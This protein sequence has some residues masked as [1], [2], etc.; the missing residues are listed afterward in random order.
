MEIASVS[1]RIEE[2]TD[3]AEA[4]RRAS[5]RAAQMGFDDVTI[6][7]AAIVV[8]EAATN[9]IKH[10]GGGEVLVGPAIN[11][12]VSGLQVIAVDKGHG[13]PNVSASLRDGY[14]T[15]GTAGNG[16]GAIARAA[17]TFDLYSQ[18][19]RGT[20]VAATIFPGATEPL[21]A[22]A[23][24]VPMPGEVECG[25]GWAIWT[26]GQ[27]TSLFL[28]DGLGHGPSAA[29]ATALAIQ[30]FRRHGERTAFEVVGYVHDALR[31]T[32]GAAVAVAELDQRENSIRYCGL[33]NISAT[34]LTRGGETRH[35][36][37]Q[38]G[39]AGHNMRRLQPFTYDWPRGC[40]LVMHSDGIGTHWSM[41]S[42]EGL[43]NRRV[44]VIAGV[45]L[46]D[47]RRGRDDATVAV[48]RNGNSA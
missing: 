39:I 40:I 22:G 1:V 35:L 37:S 28:C 31:S 17:T 34:I 15:A 38:S 27:L 11:R 36:V 44:D 13:M 14:S 3:V 29:E 16:L 2:Q 9:L 8:T 25:D 21:S 41:S 42:Y 10:A 19:G 18:P 4:R 46:R 32:R 30:T 12:G 6:G 33:G 23:V 7:R 26:A 48:V 47:H 45:I 24:S 5:D 43:T 20:V